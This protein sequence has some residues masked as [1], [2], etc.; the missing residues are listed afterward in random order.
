VNQAYV[1]AADSDG[2]SFA[3]RFME[4]VQDGKIGS[5][6]ARMEVMRNT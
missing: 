2:L 3:L 4:I 5:N 1:G 6:V